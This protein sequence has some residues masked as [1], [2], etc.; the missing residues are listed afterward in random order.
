M[1][2]KRARRTQV[3]DSTET[4]VKR[5]KEEILLDL[6][7]KRV[8]KALKSIRL[9]GNLAAYKPTDDQVDRIITAI[10]TQ[11]Q[12]VEA[13]LRGTKRDTVHFSLT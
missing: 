7:G 13:R 11:T 5:T 9:I 3:T 10:A 1:A 12:A 8:A 4:P 6:G 2:A